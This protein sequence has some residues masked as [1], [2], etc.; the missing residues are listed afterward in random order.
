MIGDPPFVGDDEAEALTVS[1]QM[2]G[3]RGSLY[4]FSPRMRNPQFGDF[5][6]SFVREGDRGARGL[7]GARCAT[8]EGDWQLAIGDLGLEGWKVGGGSKQ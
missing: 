7:K 4:K 2:F 6:C 3:F 8:G 1:E 5:P